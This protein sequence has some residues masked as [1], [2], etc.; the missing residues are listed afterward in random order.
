[1][2]VLGAARGPSP[3]IGDAEIAWWENTADGGAIWAEH[4]VDAGFEGAFS[5]FAADIDGDGDTDVLGAA[6][7]S[8]RVTWWENT[9]GDGTAWTAHN[10]D[11]TF[12]GAWS[13]SATDGD[14]DG[15]TDVL[16]AAF[17]IH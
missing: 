17:H 4:T 16:G 12:D 5:V 9:A 3:N 2:D 6:L 15:D 8:D 11:S 1:M 7:D 13:V 14:G 10:L